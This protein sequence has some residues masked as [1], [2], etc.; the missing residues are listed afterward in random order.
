MEID[1]RELADNYGQ[2]SNEELLEVGQ[3]YDALT[4]QAQEALRSEFARRKMEPPIIEPREKPQ[5][6]S[7]DLVTVRRYRDLSEA[8]VARSLLE[9]A[10]I[11]AILRDENMVR[12]E[13]QISNFLGGF[14]CK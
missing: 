11:D 14:V 6:A 9:S 10:G 13:W 5:P 3:D 12:M 7:Q 8:I 1:I 2:M 4:A